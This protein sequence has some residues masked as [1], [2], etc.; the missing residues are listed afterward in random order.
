MDEYVTEYLLKENCEAHT[1]PSK[2]NPVL[3][4]YSKLSGMEERKVRTK[5]GSNIMSKVQSTIGGP[6]ALPSVLPKLLEIL[7]G[8]VGCDFGRT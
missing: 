8:D 3:G 5:G 2:R 1:P 6:C 4:T 7:R